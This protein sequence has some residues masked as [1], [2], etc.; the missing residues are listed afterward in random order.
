MRT[1]ICFLL[2]FGALLSPGFAKGPDDEAIITAA[3]SY[4]A[5]T[6]GMTDFTAK[7]EQVVDDFARVKVAPENA[8]AADPAWI[9]LKK[10]DGKWTALTIGT[11]FTTEDYQQLGIPNALRIP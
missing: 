8:A 6:S 5:S 2:L 4:V 11:S 9:F 7:V 1:L 10:T 3:R